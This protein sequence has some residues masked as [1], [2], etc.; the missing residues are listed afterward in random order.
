[1]P[2]LSY[3]SSRGRGGTVGRALPLGD[4]LVADPAEPD[5]APFVHPPASKRAGASRF[6]V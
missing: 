3:S 2:A 4:I 1:M 6:R 5:P